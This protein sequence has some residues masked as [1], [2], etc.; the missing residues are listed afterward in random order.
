MDTDGAGLKANPISIPI[1]YRFVRPERGV[2]FDGDGLGVLLPRETAVVQTRFAPQ[3]SDLNTAQPVLQTSSGQWL[4]LTLTYRGIQP[5]LV[6]SV[7]QAT[8]PPLAVGDET[9]VLISLR[10]N[11]TAAAKF[12]VQA[13]RVR[14]LLVEAFGA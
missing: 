4:G 3:K 10:A 2:A 5:L 11:P 14:V 9:Q 12:E 6:P 7:T 13:P 1:R 8:F